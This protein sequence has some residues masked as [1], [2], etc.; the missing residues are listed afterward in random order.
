MSR[1]P[2][3]IPND[4][5]SQGS[6]RPRSPSSPEERNAAKYKRI[7]SELSTEEREHTRSLE[8]SLMRDDSAIKEAT[9]NPETVRHLGS[10]PPSRAAS[11]TDQSTSSE[12]SS[13][14]SKSS[15]QLEVSQEG[16]ID[17][18][19]PFNPDTEVSE[20]AR[21]PRDS[22]LPETRDAGQS[23]D[24]SP[25]R[26][27]NVL[28][29]S[30]DARNT[31]SD[32]PLPTPEPSS[33]S[34]SS[35]DPPPPSQGTSNELGKFDNDN[36]PSPSISPRPV[37]I[38]I[39][40]GNAESS[41]DQMMAF[42]LINANIANANLD[43]AARPRRGPPTPEHVLISVN[44]DGDIDTLLHFHERHDPLDILEAFLNNTL[45]SSA[46]DEGFDS[47]LSVTPSAPP[48]SSNEATFGSSSPPIITINDTIEILD[49]SNQSHNPSDTS[50]QTLPN[51]TIN[52][53]ADSDKEEEA[54]D[55]EE[56]KGETEKDEG[57]EE[58]SHANS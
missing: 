21:I 51:M 24:K 3:P 37:P 34:D 50:S 32:L 6:K 35:S 41:R 43:G 29:G 9:V 39:N 38:V 26:S 18:V 48:P 16:D 54:M 33:S 30:E 23:S 17:Q 49:D 5:P 2:S 14:P 25:P 22:P 11:H 27:H 57:E 15:I 28:P 56:E 42:N 47:T 40:V 55:T 36:Q 12:G 1:L 10:R 4:L 7:L 53:S 45:N 52:I 46:P 44:M 8:D 20:D 13:I 58:K 19:I 31:L